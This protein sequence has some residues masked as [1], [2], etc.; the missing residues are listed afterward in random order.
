M[1]HLLSK[2]ARVLTRN[3]V[4]I[5]LIAAILIIPCAVGAITT[6]VNYDIL[7]Y[8]PDNLDSTQGEQILENTFH[9]AAT[10]FLVVDNMESKD[11]TSLKEKI[12][13][14]PGV[15]Q[16][17]W[18]DDIADISVPKEMLP[19]AI[20]D[21]LY[22][23]N[24]KSTLMLITYDGSTSS[25][26]TLTAIGNIKKLLNKQCFLS[27]FSAIVKDTR[28]L[29]DREMPVYVAL[30]V[31]LS[32]FAM[33]FC[34]E[35]W[36]LP[37]VFML[38]IFFAVVYNFGTNIF[39]GQISYIT[40]AI[41]AILQLGVTMDYSIFLIN[42]YDEEKPKFQDRRDAMASAIKST[43]LSLAGSSMTTVAGF[44]ALCFMNLGLGK[45]IG[46]VM[47][48]GVVLGVLSTVTILPSLILL[49]DKPIHKYTHRNLFPDF[50]KSSDFLIRH[51][52]VF[53]A[54]GLLLI[55]PAAFFQANTKMYYNLDRSLPK[56]LDSIVA[57]NRV[58]KDFNMATTHFVI[59]NDN[60]KSYQVKQMS[61]QIKNLDG[62]ENV[63]AYEDFIGPSVPA[64]FIPD[65]IQNI[66]KKDG[67]Q[68]LM[69]NSRYQ[70]AEDE[71]NEQI[72]QII[73]I[74]KKADPSAM[75]TGEGALT[76]DLVEMAD[77]D[78]KV[79]NY[80]SMV[81]ILLIILLVFQSAA[82]PIV[83]VAII[84]LAIYINLGIPYL[85]GTVIPF[86]TPTVIG[87][88]QLGAT[89][90]Y[91]ILVTTRFQEELKAGHDR[92]EAIRI[93]ASTSIKSIVTSALV[94]FCATSGVAI[95]SKIEIIQSICSML[96]RGA[97]I[98]AAV[99]IF[100]LPCVL[101]VTEPIINK[102]SRHWK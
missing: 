33:M 45:D 55:G 13:E 60:L 20:K 21:V 68:I 50:T 67:K 34:M 51:R 28:D 102:L 75:V 79:T 14:V 83:L 63:F 86:I 39:L 17:V 74:T 99:I 36:V 16:A 49:F 100:I 24:E 9:D 85:T 3:P 82:I 7:S 40:K 66:C 42:R 94:F 4:V 44:F 26:E 87:C 57:L 37:F 10:S 48:K 64:D 88:V 91:S 65:S 98:S 1:M 41:A 27:G 8:L 22:S 96:A 53:V 54:L 97:I 93:A 89:V 90:D 38:G 11:I 76:K 70:S 12:K 29:T 59:L 47:M 18:V 19:S 62:V 72:D 31:V 77:H 81:C 46:I 69:V 35:S 30:A 23:D 52:K 71:E 25:E 73:K 5:V 92:R 78:F 6:R 61:A 2:F 84:E 43:F 101:Y 58:K 15:N 95:V 80:I 32:L 56:D